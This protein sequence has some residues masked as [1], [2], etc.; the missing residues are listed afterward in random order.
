MKWLLLLLCLPAFAGEPLKSFTTIDGVTHTLGLKRDTAK[1]KAF[2]AKAKK[3]TVQRGDAQVPARLDLRGRVSPPEDQG[4]HGTCWDFG[5][6]KGLRSAFMLK[7]KD[8]GRL[9][10]NYLICGGHTPYDC[11]SGGDFDAGEQFLNGKGPWLATNDPYPNCTGRCKGGPVAATASD[12]VVVGP[13]NRPPSFQEL[14]SAL[15][16][17][18]MLVIDGAVCG[19]W[20]NGTTGVLRTSECGPESINHI[21][22]RIGYDCETSV[23]A[24]GKFCVFNADGSTKNHDGYFID[25]NNWNITW[26]DGG[27][28]R[29]AWMVDAFGDTAMYFEVDA[30]PEAVDGGYSEWSV[31][32]DNQQTRSCTNPSPA[33][34]GKDCSAL[35]PATQTCASPTPPSSGFPW[36]VYGI[37]A[38]L[39]LAG[40][41]FIGVKVESALTVRPASKLGSR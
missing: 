1:L 10:F 22:N 17:P 31:C 20:G 8:P 18:H 14:A 5:T 9:S 23:T 25:M 40:G 6:T 32:L 37:G 16:S 28:I 39:I 38:L 12:W 3:H 26:S 33:N 21:I 35:G 7:G 34:G 29:E 4:Q 24:D 27:Y 36:W 19:R 15:A 41:I 2:K 13:G 11:D 30:G